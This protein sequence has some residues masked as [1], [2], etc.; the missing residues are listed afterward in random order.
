MLRTGG[1]VRGR[2]T[3]AGG[4]APIAGATVVA[5]SRQAQV[6]G[7][8]AEDGSFAIAGLADGSWSLW[9]SHDDYLR[10]DRQALPTFD[11]AG[12]AASPADIAVELLAGARIEGHVYDLAGNP[13]AGAFVFGFR[14]G[15]QADTDR[16]DEEGAFRLAGLSAGT[17]EIFARSEDYAALARQGPFSLAAG[18]VLPGADLVLEPGATIE[19]LARAD[20]SPVADVS[21]MVLG[22]DGQVRRGD[23]T[24]EGG[25]F[26]V[27]N[28]YPGR[29][30]VET[31]RNDG[32]SFAPVE[33]VV[34][35]THLGE[36][37]QLDLDLSS[38]AVVEGTVV[39]PAG[40]VPQASVYLLQGAEY[41]RRGAT[42]E[43]GRFRLDGLAAGAYD[44]YVRWARE[45]AEE[46][47]YRERIELA[48]LERREGE[49]FAAAPPAHATGIVLDAD[50]RPRAGVAVEVETR[51]PGQ[52]RRPAR[53]GDDGT[54][55]V[56]TLYD[57]DY[58]V[59][60]GE[61]REVAS[62][63]VEAGQPVEG[64][65]IRADGR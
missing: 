16:T 11:V 3:E 38:G 25:R 2:V 53:T 8:T 34:Q 13:V 17:Y 52:V 35:V 60:V 24:D 37:I 7:R 49:R 18:D 9:C 43:E 42:D 30:R 27:G 19:G 50:G 31:A 32:G 41:V 65:R 48:D 29:Y 15:D 63:H 59:H 28:L 56:D 64:L 45:E 6:D 5:M 62:F 54:F 26:E 46:L 10:P 22:I 12:G 21:I 39:G 47:V 57:G 61:A 58:V 44:L 40:P 51:T 55:R 33:T 14:D 1:T 20:G 4:T 23:Q 36:R